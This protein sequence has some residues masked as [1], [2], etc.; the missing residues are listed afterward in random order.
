MNKA[1]TLPNTDGV[2]I[3]ACAQPEDLGLTQD[4]HQIV[5]CNAS[6]V[7]SRGTS[8][9]SRAFLTE[10]VIIFP[11]HPTNISEI[12]LKQGTTTSFTVD[13]RNPIG[14]NNILQL[15]KRPLHKIFILSVNTTIL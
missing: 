3:K 12:S 6:Y 1:D 10:I 9:G 14:T 4:K 2:A 15:I 7:H 8:F 13:N 11:T 5:T